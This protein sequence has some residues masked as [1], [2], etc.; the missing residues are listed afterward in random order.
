MST[1]NPSTKTPTA[2]K[3]KQLSVPAGICYVKSTFNNTIITITDVAGH[4][5]SW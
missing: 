1:K 5:V 4:V 2:K 3:R